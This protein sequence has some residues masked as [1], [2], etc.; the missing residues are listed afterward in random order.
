[1]PYFA[2]QQFVDYFKEHKQEFSDSYGVIRIG[3]FGSAARDELQET[4]DVDIAIEMI[5]EKKNLR[6]FLGFKRLLEQ[7]FGRTVDLGIES[8][9]KPVVRASIQKEIVYV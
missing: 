5:P 4:S 7:Q 2:K 6:N 8:A 9:L 1:M 3:I